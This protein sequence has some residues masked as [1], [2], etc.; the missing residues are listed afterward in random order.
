[1]RFRPMERLAHCPECGELVAERPA[2]RFYF[3]SSDQC[4]FQTWD[5]A[6]LVFRLVPMGDA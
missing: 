3:C 2:S 6:K 1:M 5:R 4:D